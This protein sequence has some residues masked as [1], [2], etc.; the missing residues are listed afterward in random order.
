ML[1]LHSLCDWRVLEGHAEGGI[2]RRKPPSGRNHREP[3]IDHITSNDV[4]RGNGNGADEL[5][6]EGVVVL[7]L[8]DEGVDAMGKGDPEALV[9]GEERKL[10][11][12]RKVVERIIFQHISEKIAVER[13]DVNTT[14]DLLTLFMKW[15][16]VD[17]DIN[18]CAYKSDIFLR[19]T[20]LSFVTAGSGSLTIAVIVRLPHCQT[21]TRGAK[22]SA[23]VG[24]ILETLRL[25]PSIPL[26]H[27]GALKD[28]VLPSGIKVRSGMPIIIPI[29]VAE[30]SEH[31]RK[32]SE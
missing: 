24:A 2:V 12:T 19:D 29:Y 28:D 15:P 8:E 31:Y 20:A 10:A 27:K 13:H 4:G 21:P 18:S 11:T 6:A 16:M 30:N 23:G 25:F 22:D 17:D 1:V 3:F 7:D 9:P 14:L 32:S 26:D 5:G